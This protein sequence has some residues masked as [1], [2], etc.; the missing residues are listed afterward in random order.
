MKKKKLKKLLRDY[1]DAR[2]DVAVR[3]DARALMKLPMAERDRLMGEAASLIAGDYPSL[4]NS[5]SLDDLAVDQNVKPIT[6]VKELR[7]SADLDWRDG[8]AEEFLTTDTLGFD[9]EVKKMCNLD[10]NF[11]FEYVKAA[12]KDYVALSRE[13]DKLKE[14]IRFLDTLIQGPLAEAINLQE[15]ANHNNNLFNEGRIK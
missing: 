11:A 13:C 5:P 1:R 2:P 9:E 7:R 3:L 8:T 15:E 6:D 14:R 10:I 4:Y 12:N